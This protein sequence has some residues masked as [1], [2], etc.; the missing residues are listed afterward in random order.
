MQKNNTF[1][2]FCSD[3]R[4]VVEPSINETIYYKKNTHIIKINVKI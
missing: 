1:N 3:G 4:F 2:S